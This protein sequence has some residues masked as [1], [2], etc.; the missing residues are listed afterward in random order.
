MSDEPADST[1][2]FGSLERVA[3]RTGW[4]NESQAFTPWLAQNLDLLG[5]QLGLALE[6]KEKEHPVGRFFVDL[7]LTDAQERVVIVENQLEQ[8]DHDHLGKLLTYCAGTDARVVIWVAPSFSD[9][10]LAALEWLNNNTVSDVAFFAVEVELLRIGS[11]PLAPNFKALIKPNQWVKT[12]RSGAVQAAEWS[13][14]SYGTELNVSQDRLAIARSIVDGLESVIADRELPWQKRFRKGY[15][16]F[17]RP[18]GYNVM[19]VDLIWNKPVRVS[20]KSQVP[21]SELGIANPYPQLP[22]VWSATSAEWGW[23]VPTATSVDPSVVVDLALQ[24]Q[25]DPGGS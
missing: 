23:H 17:Q 14:E 10:H 15:I 11:S 5:Q 13:W 21:L 2:T 25:P 9:E 20:L 24:L 18:G 22:A 19:V 4:S 16:A 8:S 12:T 1:A 6:L 7:L 3:L